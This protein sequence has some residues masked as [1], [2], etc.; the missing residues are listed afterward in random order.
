[1]PE[2]S[3]A[4]L[5]QLGIVW[6]SLAAVA[7]AATGRRM[8]LSG[9]VLLGP[10]CVSFTGR[11]LRAALAGGWAVGLVVILGV[12]DGIWGSRL[13]ITLI[14]AGVLVAAVS[15]LALIVTVRACLTLTV[16]AS[17]AAAC[18]SPTAPGGPA[19]SAA[20]P[21]SCP[22]QYQGWMH[23][24]GFAQY[25]RLQG[26]V[27]AARTA[28]RSGN[29]VTLK[30]AMNKLMPAAV[31]NG[32]IAPVPH[33]ADPAGLYADYVTTVY[34]A[35]YEARTAKGLSGLRK[36]ATRLNGLKNIESQ[37]AAEVNRVLAKPQRRQP[38]PG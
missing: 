15:T 5:W 22:Q 36:A 1:L 33:C 10:V 9:L 26:D 37:L 34:Q 21:V 32:H 19:V 29:A 27:E 30:S 24:A 4:L 35:G 16:T 20:R 8:V 18:G 38:A 3:A 28:E 14:A 13:Q 25:R 17:L 23:G 12:P 6:S 7:D 11:W 2:P 31:A